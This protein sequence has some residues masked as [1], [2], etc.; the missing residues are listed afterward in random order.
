MKIYLLLNL[1]VN[2]NLIILKDKLYSLL[3]LIRKLEK[4]SHLNL[5]VMQKKMTVIWILLAKCFKKYSLGRNKLILESFLLKV[6]VKNT[7]MYII[8]LI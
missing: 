8:F 2:I 4:N 5:G 3:I 6:L 1:L 7:F